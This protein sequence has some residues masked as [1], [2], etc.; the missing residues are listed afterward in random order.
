[1]TKK[2]CFLTVKDEVWVYLNGLQPADSDFLWNKYG[3]HVDGYFFMPAYKLGRWD[4]KI[5]FFEK[6]GKTYLR[7][8][9]EII[10]YLDKWGYDLE[11]RDE[12]IGW[13]PCE[14]RV[15]ADWFTQNGNV[16]IK[17]RPYQFDAVNLALENGCGFIIAGTG[18]G[19]SLICAALCDAY[20]KDNHKTI[21]IVPSSDL[22][23]QTAKWYQICGMDVGEYS[24]ASKDLDHQHIVATWQSLQNN[25]NL[26]KLFQVFVW[27][28]VHGAKAS[29]AQKLIAEAGKNIPF[30]FGV[31]GTFPKPEADRLALLSTIGPIL[32]EISARW[33]ID[34]GYLAEIEIDVIRTKDSVFSDGDFP[35]YPS[36]RAYISRSENRLD[37]IADLVIERCQKYGNTLVL[38]NSIDFGKKLQALIKDSVFL[39]GASEKDERKM[40]YDTFAD[41]NDLIVIATSGIA[42]TGISIDRVFCLMLIDAG[43][44]FIKAIQSVGRG[45][46]LA[47]DKNKVYVTDV[48]ADLKWSKKHSNE[49]I[50]YFKEAK[51]PFHKP[52]VMKI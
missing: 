14:R 31:T 44:S 20:G 26:M 13:A 3:V 39:Y 43:K 11:L 33:L 34:N 24:G 52:V 6:T 5:R 49:R 23:S 16:D 46:R 17:L 51:Y 21:T 8:L 36:E 29:V 27:D 19:K 50:K 42:S 2:K 12:R 15:D 22:V 18:A 9:P 28:E 32:T 7:L 25:P 45:T 41:Q 1:M 35:D 10:E 48:C 40:H 47:H 30:R 4:G 38:V 37:F